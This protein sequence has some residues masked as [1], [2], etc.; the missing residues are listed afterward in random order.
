MT[1]LAPEKATA[2][3]AASRHS[4]AER[5]LADETP[6]VRSLM[7]AARLDDHQR[8]EVETLARRLVNAVRAGRRQGGGVDAFMQE[9]SLSSD[10]GIVLMCL[11]EALLRIPDA[12]TQDKLIADKVGGRQ[13]HEHIGQ[14]DSLFVNASTWGLMLTGH[15]IGFRKEG[16]ADMLG[17]ARRLVA[18][19]GEPVIRQALRQAMRIMGK[20]FVL[21]RTIKEALEVAAPQEKIGYRFSFDM[22]GEAAMTAVDADRYLAAYV[23]ALETVARHAGALTPD[24][25]VYERPSISVK[26]S[27]IHP[28]YE[29][30]QE[31]RVLAELLPRILK[32][33]E[34]AR[35]LDLGITID[36]EEAFRLDLSLALFERLSAAPS[37]ARWDGLGLAV[38]AYG[39]R[40]Y[41]ALEWL[42]QLG[43]RTNRRIPIRLVKGAYWDTEIK[44][45]QEAGLEGYPVFT[46]KANTDVSYL[47]CA[48]FMLSQKRSIYPQFATHNAHTVA[49]I[50]VMGQLDADFEFQRLH[51]MGQA[52]YD[53]VVGGNKLNRPCRI[54][55]PVGTHEDLLAYLVRR[56]LENGA[57]TSFVHRLAN[58]E[59]P[60]RE[61]IADPVEDIGRH[62]SIPHSHIPLP[63]D[64]FKPRKNSQGF[65]LWDDET[66]EQFLKRM[67]EAAAE[68][69]HAAPLIDGTAV[70]GAARN[71]TS[72]QDR[73]RVVGTVVEADAAA[74]ERALSLSAKVRRDWDDLGG[75]QRAAILE[76]AADQYEAQV[77]RLVGLMTQEAGKTI[78][79]ALADHREAVDF[80]RFY[81]SEARAKFSTGMTL[82]G[83]TGE[84]NE[85][86]L[87]GRGTFA[88]ISPWNFPLA[89]FTGQIA[90][91][92][93]AGNTVIAKP[94]EQTPLVAF[95]AVRLM[96]HAGVPGSVLHLLPGGGA[97]VG[98]R[99]IADSRIDGVAFTGS[100]ETAA[101]INRALAARSGAI[102]PLIAETG[103]MNAMIVDST[104]LPEQAVRDV[105]MS[106]FD[107]AGQ[108]CSAARLLFVQRDIADR[109]LPMLKGAMEELRIGDPADYATDVG[110]VIDEDAANV[111]IAHKQRMS[112]EARTLID[113]PLPAETRHGTFVSPAAYEIDSMAMLEREVFGPILHVVRYDGDKLS[114]VCD[115]VN[116][117]GYGLTLGLHT[118]IETTAEEVRK[119]VRVGNVYV[120]RNQIGAV[121]GSQPFGGEGLSGTGPKAGGPHYLYR[122]ATERVV[123]TD[124]TASG[125]NT[126]LF[127]MVSEDE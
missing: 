8:R 124:T 70:S 45:A 91:A 127:S 61:I 23:N 52:L 105:V 22:L 11:A 58:D 51:G 74:V 64:I 59:A 62:V 47:A 81:A 95:E 48:R 56:L 85:M 18:R 46:R 112:R 55:A 97:A 38:Q 88:C 107:S 60:I 7:E 109:L 118:R 41:P 120:N 31:T 76:R 102:V 84:R 66:R 1:T 13:W 42:A 28:R 101:L 53:E 37:L 114:E 9:Y 77:H 110:P 3:S 34:R 94:A 35:D 90:A 40:A 117:S 5:L 122:F 99:L 79:N 123:S 20:Q 19:S 125:G 2:R 100:N 115:A 71:V 25:K 80:L 44:R 98:G 39:K 121:V 119:R 89:I 21:G 29:P 33:C 43:E 106:A 65:P 63:R 68:P 87:Y 32:L 15:V 12:A 83:P 16:S 104:A 103:G 86:W 54:Y 57:N 111:L 17:I 116:G 108:R 49:A 72:P 69:T 82:P 24:Q 78:D 113:L 30:K 96:H 73:R 67:A 26:L 27:A 75:Y 10:E 93:A 36:A 4:I 126:S 6:L 14:S 92:L 50:T